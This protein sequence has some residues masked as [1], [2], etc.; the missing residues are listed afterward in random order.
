MMKAVDVNSGEK[1]PIKGVKVNEFGDIV[2][3][4]AVKD[5]NKF[6]LRRNKNGYLV[7]DSDDFKGRSF[8]CEG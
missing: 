6:N 8:I 5:D 7:S 2:S 1:F 3:Y 4:R